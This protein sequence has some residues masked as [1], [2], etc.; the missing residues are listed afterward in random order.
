M[1]RYLIQLKE[2]NIV[3]GDIDGILQPSVLNEFLPQV[4]E[5]TH[6]SG[7]LI[8]HAYV[9]QDLIDMFWTEV[10]VKYTFFSDHDSARISFQ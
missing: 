8:D 7:S 2:I 10:T 9:H 6:I 4:C 1:L 5:P 3:V